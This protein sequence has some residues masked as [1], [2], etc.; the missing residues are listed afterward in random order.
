MDKN[1]AVFEWIKQCPV[2]ERLF[3]NFGTSEENT[4]TF[5]PI[6]TDSTVKTDIFG[7]ETKHYDFAVST[8]GAID[9]ITFEGS[10]NITVMNL[11]QQLTEWIKLQNREKNFPDFGAKCFIEKI[12]VNQNI[13]ASLR[14]QNISKYLSQY[15]IIYEERTD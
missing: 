11:M 12:S 10:E 4:S 3:F 14:M 15:R 7:N 2:F 1:K 13:P 6:P 9:D 5:I 8:F